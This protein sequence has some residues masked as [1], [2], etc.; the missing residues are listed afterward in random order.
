MVRRRAEGRLGPTARP[1]PP[2]SGAAAIAAVVR[3]H[4]PRARRGELLR[5]SER[6]KA[7]ARPRRAHQRRRGARR[8]ALARSR[9]TDGKRHR[10]GA[11]R[12]HS[13]HGR[14][15]GAEESFGRGNVDG[16]VRQG[17]LGRRLC[18]ARCRTDTASTP[19]YA[20]PRSAAPSRPFLCS[21][22]SRR[23]ALRGVAAVAR[24]ELDL[25]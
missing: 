11:L 23:G 25:G 3:S 2:M 21:Q 4:L 20:A 16:H 17:L 6:E 1:R 7:P 24:F 8:E 19:H 12:R 9:A 14:T 18:L 5:L 10:T 22:A 15:T 13:R